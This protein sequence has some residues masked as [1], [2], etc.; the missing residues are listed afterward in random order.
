[1]IS[2]FI[3]AR[4]VAAEASGK[5]ASVT[6]NTSSAN[7][8][9]R[10]EMPQFALLPTD[11]GTLAQGEQADIALTMLEQALAHE[12]SDD[13]MFMG[14]M[15]SA[16]MASE[17]A[18][19]VSMSSV[20]MAP[21]SM[22][23]VSMTPVNMASANVSYSGQLNP[24]L[25]SPHSAPL[26]SVVTTASPYAAQLGFSTAMADGGSDM[27]MRFAAAGSDS[28][29]QANAL[30]TLVNP[31]KTA[32]S[33]PVGTLAN[34]NQAHTVTAVDNGG[35]ALPASLVK[36]GGPGAEFMPLANMNLASNT[37]A[38]PATGV[39]TLRSDPSLLPVMAELRHG[40]ALDIASQATQQA[41]RQGANVSQWG[42]VSVSPQASVAQQAHEML[43]PMRE[44]LR[45]QIDQRIKHAE[46][47]LDPPE[48]GKVELNIRLDGDRLHIQMHA[49]NPAVR[50]ALL[51][52]LERLRND[53]AQDHGGH[54]E[55]DIGQNGSGGE[56]QRQQQSAGLNTPSINGRDFEPST[57]TEMSAQL[58]QHQ[59]N[60]LA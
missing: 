60:L 43:T 1:M 12:L 22:A 35:V 16:S 20:S 58:H 57:E 26:A 30:A 48:L 17:I 24:E 51:T 29:T 9:E 38:L 46:L 3:M 2:D 5:A 34:Q 8:S 36:G 49:V 11:K 15:S 19:A 41:G 56:Q 53:L 50:E 7:M 14:E 42:P 10:E 55:L 21:A 39:T 6:A 44:Q 27:V 4:P 13:P 28:A 37:S 47:R 25:L 31:M 18:A 33:I 45:F 52:G 23:A 54:I 40:E 32:I 59:L